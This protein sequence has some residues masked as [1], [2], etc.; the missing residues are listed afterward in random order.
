MIAPDEWV[1]DTRSDDPKHRSTGLGAWLVSTH[2]VK[3]TQRGHTGQSRT[4]RL[5]GEAN[6]C[7]GKKSDCYYKTHAA[8][9]TSCQRVAPPCSRAVRLCP[10]CPRCVR[11]AM[12][13]ETSHAWQSLRSNTLTQ[14]TSPAVSSRLTERGGRRSRRRRAR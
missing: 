11:F 9:A 2:I 14:S 8:D 3:R 10:A 6:C 13:V 7:G 1:S 4:A 12:S 5:Q